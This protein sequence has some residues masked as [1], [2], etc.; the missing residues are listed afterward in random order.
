MQIT[1][2]WDRL[3]GTLDN[4]S[5]ITAGGQPADPKLAHRLIVGPWG[6]D[7]TDL[8]G[9]L[10]PVD[11][12]PDADRT[13]AGLVQRWFDFQLR[14]INN[15]LE[16]EDPV[17]LFVPGEN[18]WRG[19]PEWPLV[20]AR[21]LA[22]Y[23]HS[24]GSAATLAGDGSLSAVPPDDLPAQPDRPD[25]GL[26]GGRFGADRD[27]YEYD[28]RDPVMSL[29]RA[30]SQA[31]PVDQAPHDNRPDILFYETGRLDRSLELIGDVRLHLWASTDAPDTDW[32][33]KLAVVYEDGLAVN[34][35]YGI[36]RAQ[37]RFGYER[38]ELLVA[39]EVC[40]YVIVLN[41]VGV[42]LQPG[43]K[44]R[45]SVSSSDFPNFDRNHNTG[46]PYWCDPELSTARQTV[47]H[48]AEMPSRLLLTMPS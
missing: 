12:G 14:G 26:L 15:G 1:G 19:E 22:L 45:L 4:F 27:E 10:G 38:P 24:G 47:Y 41:P 36:M 46:R 28:P 31:V 18:R 42:R 11:Y 13:Y 34:L 9:R 43:Q 21:E 7:S 40:E 3:I 6:H 30:D 32:T 2:W 39:G 20:A 23:L 44:L 29:M 16:T 5:G 48:S 17:Q 25:L 8:T 37:Y 33:A 35:T